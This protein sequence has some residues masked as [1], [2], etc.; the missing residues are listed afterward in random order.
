MNALITSGRDIITGIFRAKGA[1]QQTAV[2]AQ[3]QLAQQQQN[4]IMVVVI[5]V[6]AIIG[7]LVFAGGV[8]GR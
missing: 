7:F 1:Q 8:R 6:L 2:K 4:T 5:G 3:V